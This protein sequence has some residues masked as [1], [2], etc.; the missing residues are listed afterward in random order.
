VKLKSSS[1]GATSFIADLFPY[2]RCDR[3][4][5]VPTLSFGKSWGPRFGTG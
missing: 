4:G 2:L 1:I 3:E 5:P